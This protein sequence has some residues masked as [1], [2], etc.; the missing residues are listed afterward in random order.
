MGHFILT[1]LFYLFI[2]IGFINLIHF[3]LYL[4]GANLYDLKS[5]LS[6]KRNRPLVA[7]KPLV[8]VLVPAF[9]EEKVIERCLKSIWSNTYEKIQIIVIND[10][11]S[12]QTA[13]AVQRFIRSRACT[14]NRVEPKI[15]RTKNGLKRVW[16]RGRSPMIRQIRLVQQ[17]NTGKARALN[18][19]LRYY[20][21]GELIMTLD[22]DSLIHKKAIARAVSYF[23]TPDVVGVAANVRIIDEFTVL[24][25]LQRFEHMIGYRSKKFFTLANCE[26]II[27][28]VASTY[29]KTVL[30]KVGYYDTDTVTEDIGLSMKIAA[31]GNK[32]YRLVYAAD[33]AAMTEG[34]ANFRALLAQRYRWKLG[35]LQNIVKYRS[36]LFNRDERYTKALTYYR[37]PMAF[38]GELLI[39]LELFVLAYVLYLSIHYFTIGLVLGAYTTITLYIL[40]SIWPDEH[41]DLRGKI[42]AS[43][44][45]PWLYFIF[46]LMNAI[47]VISIIRCLIEKDKIINLKDQKNIWVSPRRLGKATSFS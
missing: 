26:F 13:E 44:L 19:G 7:N 28:G 16:R 36:M 39:L 4:V 47:Q 11:S 2:A 15:V 20:A 21:K 23:D 24:G 29:R 34:V 41:L 46:Y 8:S 32:K 3:G 9:N 40:L 12:D 18:R 33:V 14:Y 10:G 17:S 45:A 6:Q 42:K 22:A 37:M 35:G 27:G 5:W 43:L 31:L 38:I 1:S 30:D 25:I